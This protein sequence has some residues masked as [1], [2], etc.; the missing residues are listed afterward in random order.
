MPGH[1]TF[2][3]G[4]FRSSTPRCVA[5]IA[6]RQRFPAVLQ[7]CN[8][9]QQSSIKRIRKSIP[10]ELWAIIILGKKSNTA[11]ICLATNPWI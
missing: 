3:G 7:S 10:D 5:H 11:S 1:G 8:F 4:V 2:D 9:S 6:A